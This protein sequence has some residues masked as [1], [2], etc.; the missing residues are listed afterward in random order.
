MFLSDKLS[1]VPQGEAGS[2]IGEVTVV[3]CVLST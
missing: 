3:E 1:I 2:V